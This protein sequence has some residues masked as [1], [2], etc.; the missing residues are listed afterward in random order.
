MNRTCKNC[1]NAFDKYLINNLCEN[2]TPEQKT[3]EPEKKP[4]SDLRGLLKSQY[5]ELNRP[6]LDGKGGF[7]INRF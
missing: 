3:V 1:K 2:C 6:S 5:L 7:Y 4:Q